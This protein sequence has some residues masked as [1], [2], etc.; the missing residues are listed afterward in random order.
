MFWLVIVAIAVVALLVLDRLLLA[1]EA[2]GWV[3][4]RRSGL[5]RGAA[6]YH[7][8]EMSSA[9]DPS[10]KEVQ[11]AQVEDHEEQDETGD[12]EGDREGKRG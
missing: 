9:F 7:I 8:L 1:A 4:Y 2:R 3:N 10:F 12:P 11:E 6:T 5:S